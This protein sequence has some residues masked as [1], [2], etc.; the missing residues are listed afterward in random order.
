MNRSAVIVPGE[1]AAKI[2]SKANVSF[3]RVRDA[4][5]KVDVKHAGHPGKFSRQRGRNFANENYLSRELRQGG[6]IERSFS[7]LQSGEVG[8]ALRSFKV[9]KWSDFFRSFRAAKW[10]EFFRSFKAAKWSEAL[11][12]REAA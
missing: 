11:R 2:R 9:A 10:S 6:G 8:A 7:K 12:S 3:S 1:A 5:Q 4:A